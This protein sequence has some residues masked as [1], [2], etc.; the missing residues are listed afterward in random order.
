[1]NNQECRIRAE[2]VNINSNEPL[3]YP[4]KKQADKCSSICN[5]IIDPF[6]KL[7]VHD[8]GKI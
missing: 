2:I 8:V 4:F 1:M 5:N 7:C 3:F 6:A